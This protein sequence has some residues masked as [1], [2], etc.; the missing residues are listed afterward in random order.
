MFYF[1]RV[2]YF[3]F[4][5]TFYHQRC[6]S[7]RVEMNFMKALERTLEASERLVSF[8]EEDV[9]KV[10]L[11]AIY[12]LRVAEGAWALCLKKYLNSTMADGKM[13]RISNRIRKI[14]QKASSISNLAQI[15]IKHRSPKYYATFKFVVDKPWKFYRDFQ[16]NKIP[17][18]NVTNTSAFKHRDDFSEGT[19][20]RCMSEVMGTNINRTKCTVTRDCFKTI[21][22]QNSFGY[23]PTH[24][25]LFLTLAIMFR[26]ETKYSPILKQL[27][28]YDVHGLIQNRCARVMSELLRLERLEIPVGSRD[29][30]IEQGVV[31]GMHGFA[32][33]MTFKRLY[34]VLSWQRKYGCFG[35]SNNDVH[36]SQETDADLN[37]DHKVGEGNHLD[38]LKL[39]G[40]SDDRKNKDGTPSNDEHSDTLKERDGSRDTS[41][42]KDESNTVSGNESYMGLLG[43]RHDISMNRRESRSFRSMRK[44]LMD[45]TVDHGCSSH[46]SGVAAGL[47]GLYTKWILQN[48]YTEEN[49]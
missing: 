22:N 40:S 29:L 47:L 32:E 30:Y 39:M 38:Y 17:T 18:S 15:F 6:I 11:D 10:N 9:D 7:E 35:K 23:G 45:V 14:H 24:Q 12:G 44:L 48:I 20:D 34:N 49:S 21:T 2:L 36:N 41:D 28:G 4:M 3:T 46:E 33:F 19:S 27:S 31:C 1:I 5:L 16:F 42:Y 13:R 25:V 43:I 8:F 37:H 26:C